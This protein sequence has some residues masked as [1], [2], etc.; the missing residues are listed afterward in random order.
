MCGQ[1]VKR[2]NEMTNCFD[3][4]PNEQAR[5]SGADFSAMCDE[6]KQLQQRNAELKVELMQ[7]RE[8][9]KYL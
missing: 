8:R 6:M 3:Q 7:I 5:I 2:R 9:K 1:D 4:D